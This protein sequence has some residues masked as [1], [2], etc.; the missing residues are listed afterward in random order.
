MPLTPSG[1]VSDPLTLTKFRSTAASGQTAFEATVVGARWLIGPSANAY[2]YDLG[3]GNYIAT[4]G[5]LYVGGEIQVPLVRGYSAQTLALTNYVNDGASA[6]GTSIDTANAFSTAG[7]KILSIKTGGSEKAYI[8]KD[9]GFISAASSG[10]TAFSMPNNA[11]LYFGTDRYMFNDGSGFLTVSGYFKADILTSNTITNTSYGTLSTTSWVN[12][13]ASAKGFKFTAGTPATTSLTTAGAKIV[14]FENGVSTEKAYIDKD[15]QLFGGFGTGNAAAVYAGGTVHVDTTAV[16][17]VGTGEDDLITYS[18]PA[19]SLVT[20]GKG[21]RST[22]WGST[23]GG[24]PTLKVYI[25]S[26]AVL[27]H[28]LPAT[29]TW[30]VVTTVFR[31]GSNA[32][33]YVVALNHNA[34]GGDDCDL[35]AGT[36]TETET[37]TISLKLTGDATS[38]NDIVQEG[39]HVE[40]I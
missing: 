40:A 33:K 20:T 22:A 37:A 2:F 3:A 29:S 34:G 21:I 18:L 36:L 38:N 19:N 30:H 23:S 14:S 32:Q 16:G 25:G 27:T 11:R 9:G 28:A 10:Q 1:S 26:T 12:D 4:P 15:G 8:S 31:T 13:G 17:N 39:L 7:S 6:V 5:S 35:A 24:T